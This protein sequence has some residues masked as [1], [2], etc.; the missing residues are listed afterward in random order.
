MSSPSIW[1]EAAR[2]GAPPLLLMSP[3]QAAMMTMAK[4]QACGMKREAEVTK[5]LFF[6]ASSTC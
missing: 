3:A 1:T 6:M 2:S 5:E 4:I